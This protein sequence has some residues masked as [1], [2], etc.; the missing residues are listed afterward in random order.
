MSE[1]KIT[2]A[3]IAQFHADGY[4]IVPQL[5]DAEEIDLLYK[6]GKADHHLAQ[7]AVAR[8]DAQGVEV[9]LSLSN[10]LND[11][12]YAAYVRCH[13]IVDTM[14]ALLEDEVYH[15]HNKMIM[16]EP[17]VGGA[18]EWHQDY[19]YWYG[20][21]CLYPDM[22]SCMI[23]VDRATKENGCL[24]VITGSHKMGRME[25]GKS[26]EQTGANMERVNATLERLPIAYCEMEP[27]SAVF[28]H[29]NTLHRS[30]QNRSANPRWAFICCYNSRHNNPYK[31][32]H[33]PSYSYLE[34]WDD[35]K[36]KEVGR[37][38]WASMA[39]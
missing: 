39:K 37:R 23:A 27:G 31:E 33:H 13:R 14:Q 38:Q 36:V 15:Y 10:E 35:A 18:W 19:G 12:I 17:F 28:F 7:T 21:G 16:K 29:S 6:I 8:L 2:E 20:N 5:F 32:S 4:L 30:D 1:F 11:D 34:K 3:Q 9:K 25:H 22:A 24:Q 26:G